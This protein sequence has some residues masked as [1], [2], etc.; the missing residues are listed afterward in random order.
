MRNYVNYVLCL[1]FLI[2]LTM[3]FI[4]I[5]ANGQLDDGASSETV[6]C[7]EDYEIVFKPSNNVPICVKSSSV[8]NFLDRG[9][10]LPISTQD[11][12]RIGL[13]FSTTGDYSTHG[14]ESQL[15]ALTA[16]DDFNEHLKSVDKETMSLIPEI[17]YLST[18]PE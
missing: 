1:S 4:D 18:N 2:F 15:A 8:E 14:I 6:I 16:I 17:V 9:Y 12:L 13:L 11:N 7:A 3:S 10:T 5:G